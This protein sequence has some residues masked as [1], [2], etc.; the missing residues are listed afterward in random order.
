MKN[1]LAVTQDELTTTREELARAQEEAVKEGQV[2]RIMAQQLQGVTARISATEVRVEEV[3]DS[4]I[5][6]EALPN[7]SLSG[8]KG[9]GGGASNYTAKGWKFDMLPQ[10]H[11]GG[12]WVFPNVFSGTVHGNNGD[13]GILDTTPNSNGT[14]EASIVVSPPP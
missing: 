14:P 3:A 12:C 13:L 2:K 4:S 6:L 7:I 5:P 1:T 8:G 10:V 9:G 11:G